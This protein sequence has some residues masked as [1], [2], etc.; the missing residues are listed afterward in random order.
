ME[1]GSARFVKRK[2]EEGEKSLQFY[3]K[4]TSKHY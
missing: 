4:V 1:E 3:R 2:G